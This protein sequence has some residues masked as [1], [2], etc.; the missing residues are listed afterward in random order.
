MGKQF[1][2]IDEIHDGIEKLVESYRDKGT[3]SRDVSRNN[4]VKFNTGNQWLDDKNIWLM[5]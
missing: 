2:R 3:R 5:L 4:P 1:L